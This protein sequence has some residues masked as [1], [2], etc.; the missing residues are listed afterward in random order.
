MSPSQPAEL[1]G[2]ALLEGSRTFRGEAQREAFRSLGTQAGIMGFQ[3]PPPFCSLV[4][5]CG[6]VLC[7]HTGQEHASPQGKPW[8]ET[9]DSEPKETF[10]LLSWVL[11]YSNTVTTL[12]T[13]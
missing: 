9:L 11:C 12:A 1:E 4:H 3:S 13:V 2:S 5:N 7:Y 6:E 8:T 10:K